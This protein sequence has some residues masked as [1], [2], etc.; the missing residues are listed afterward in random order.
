MSIAD[1]I[2]QVNRYSESPN[3]YVVSDMTAFELVSAWQIGYEDGS[4]RRESGD[5]I[6]YRPEVWFVSR[7]KVIDYTCGFMQAK[8]E[9]E[10]GPSIEDD[11][12]TIR[13][14]GAPAA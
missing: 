3:R 8:A 5:W 7:R 6:P 4:T 11:Y 9:L 2:V 12:D 1:A 10:P 14:A 13:M